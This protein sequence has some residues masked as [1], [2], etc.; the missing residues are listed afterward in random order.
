MAAFGESTAPACA[1]AS[2]C[3]AALCL[4]LF[5]RHASPV[6]DS[7][8][9]GTLGSA[10][11]VAAP[12]AVLLGGVLVLSVFSSLGERGAFDLYVL[13]LALPP[14]AC[15]WIYGRNAYLVYMRFRASAADSLW[16]LAGLLIAPGVALACLAVQRPL[17]GATLARVL[18]EDP[19]DE[20][21]WIVLTRPLVHRVALAEWRSRWDAAVAEGTPESLALAERI[22]RAH[23]QL[24]GVSFDD[25]AD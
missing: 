13:A 24:T 2:V 5:S 20:A 12:F 21:A 14:I 7:V 9:A 11:L 1:Y 23:E 16:T 8:L 22:A 18:T 17:A 4:A 15:T 10:L 25:A 6:V 3:M 19:H